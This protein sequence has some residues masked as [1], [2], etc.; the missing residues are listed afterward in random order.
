MY[1]RILLALSGLLLLTGL[2]SSASAAPYRSHSHH[3]RRHHSGHS[4]GGGGFGSVNLGIR[5]AKTSSSRQKCP[6]KMERGHICP[7]EDGAKPV[8]QVVPDGYLPPPAPR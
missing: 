5:A 1:T 2:E 4:S 6:C 7:C 3:A 8:P